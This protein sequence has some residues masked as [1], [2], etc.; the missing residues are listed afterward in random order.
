[1]PP[2]VPG[3]EQ[4]VDHVVITKALLI[5]QD[6]ESSPGQLAFLPPALPFATWMMSCSLI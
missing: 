6:S 4:R 2:V 3:G 5:V 1:M